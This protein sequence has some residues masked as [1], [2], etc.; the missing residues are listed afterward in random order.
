[1]HGS[2]IGVTRSDLVVA[3]GNDLRLNLSLY[4]GH[5]AEVVRGYWTVFDD[6]Q[7]LETQNPAVSRCYVCD[8]AV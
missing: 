4:P 7:V 8:V 2:G 6:I 1:M 5:Q 3:G